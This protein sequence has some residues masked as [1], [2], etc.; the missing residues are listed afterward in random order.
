MTANGREPMTREHWYQAVA[1][2]LPIIASIAL[3]ATV[4][5]WT[6]SG[7]I[8]EYEELDSARAAAMTARIAAIE[9]QEA[10]DAEWRAVVLQQLQHIS[11]RLDRD[12]R[13]LNAP[14]K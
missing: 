12:Q 7:R 4:A 9:A 10:R 13:V 2:I 14:N 5:G 11:D 3:A 8:A 1:I 6:V